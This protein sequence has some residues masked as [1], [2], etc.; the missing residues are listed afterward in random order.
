MRWLIIAAS[1]A[2]FSTGCGGKKAEPT[3]TPPPLLIDDRGTTMPFEK[4]VT[5]IGFRPYVPSTEVLAV[6]VLPPLGDLDNNKN[7]G[8][9]FE[10]LAGKETMLLSQWPKQRFAISFG[11]GQPS[12]QD[13]TPT[14]YS[15]QAVAWTTP[16]NLVMTLQP[17]GA[18]PPGAVDREARRLIRAGACR[19]R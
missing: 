12:L 10:Y 6:A 2:L 18:A 19:G 1:L 17:D 9:A 4:A 7:R 14:H 8:I 5:H 15:S 11:A 3:T 13:C 16:G